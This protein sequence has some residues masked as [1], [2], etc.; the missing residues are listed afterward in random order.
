MFI[1]WLSKPINLFVIGFLGGAGLTGF[2]CRPWTSGCTDCCHW[3]TR[4]PWSCASYWSQ[5]HDQTTLWIDSKDLLYFF[6]H[7]SRRLG[8]TNA[9]DQGPVGGVDHRKS[10]STTNVVLQPDTVPISI[11]NAITGT[12]TASGAWGWSFSCLCQ[13]KRELCWSLRERSRHEWLRD[14][15]VVRRRKFSPPGC[16]KKTL[17]GANN[18]LQHPFAPWSSQGWCWGS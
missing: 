2:L 18:R 17:W 14:I 12:R 15:R 16:H 3:A 13:H 7:G 1:V 8:A 4:T 10:D 9:K 11:I 5:C 6:V